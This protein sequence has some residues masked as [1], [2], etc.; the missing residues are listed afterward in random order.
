MF[1]P[2]EIRSQITRQ[3]VKALMNGNLPPWR[4]PWTNDPNAP[5]L[6][7]SL[8]TGN[9]YPDNLPTRAGTHG[10]VCDGVG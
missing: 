6:H 10:T 8:S 3:I 4:R 5:G 9:P 7:R 1:G 2:N